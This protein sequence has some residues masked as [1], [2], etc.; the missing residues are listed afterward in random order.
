MKIIIKPFSEIM[1]KSKPVRKRYLQVLQTN[2]ARSLKM[3]DENIKTHLFYDKLEI[4]FNANKK[5]QS[6]IVNNDKLEE[7]KIGI[8]KKLKFI[9]WI[10]FFIDVESFKIDKKLIEKED[11]KEVFDFIFS[12]C[13]DFYLNKITNKSFVSRVRRNGIHNFSSIDLERYVWG[14]LLKYSD[15]A[16]V[17]LKNPDITIKIE[18]KN[19]DLFLVRDKFFWIGWYPVWTQ[20]KIISLISGWFDSWVSTYS[21]MK[22][23]CKVDYLFFNLWGSAHEL[24]VKQVSSYLWKNFWIWYDARFITIPFEDVIKELVEKVESR[25]R[26]ILLKRYFLKIADRLSKEHK[27]YAIVKWDSLGQ[28]SSQT[29]KNMFVIDKASET[30]VLRPLISFNKQEIVDITKDIGTYDFACNMPEYCWVISDKPATWARLEQVLEQEEKIDEI[31]LDRAIESKKVEYLKNI[32]D[33]KLNSS[34]EE[35]EISYI[36]WKDEIVIDIRKDEDIKKKSLHLENTKILKIPFININS[37]FKKLDQTKTY[38]FYCDKWVLSKLHWLYLKE[39]WFNNI[40]I[41]RYLETWCSLK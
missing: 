8:I 9:P 37:E 14:G 18:V 28:V 23:G 34:E 13:K 7:I 41:Y 4:N 36:P 26:W 1:I 32:L 21:M 29:L 17:K 22:R 25:F 40:K 39:L 12:K 27:Y 20:D 19:D 11:N 24:W 2:I 35:I 5:E 3:I 6:D 16:K 38:L 30:L 10:E 33:S 31:I 15:N